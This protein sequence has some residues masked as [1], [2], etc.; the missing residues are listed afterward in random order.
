MSPKLCKI[1]SWHQEVVFQFFANNLFRIMPKCI[2]YHINDAKHNTLKWKLLF[3]YP[4]SNILF[5]FYDF[6]KIRN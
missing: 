6:P 1:P 2:H 3:Y 4:L 5:M